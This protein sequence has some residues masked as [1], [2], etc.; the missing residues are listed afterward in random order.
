[1]IEP[2]ELHGKR[3]FGYSLGDLGLMLPRTFEGVFIF[4]F[5]VYTI[6]LNSLLVSI[7]FSAQLI[8]GAISAIIFGVIVDNKKPGK[9]GKRRPFLILGLPIWFI[10]TILVWY[11][12]NCPIDNSF[13]L[14][15]AS[16]FWISIIVRAISHALIYTVYTSMLPE[17]SQT[18]KNREKIASFSSFF[19]IIASVLAL[20]LPIIIQSI[21]PDPKMVKWWNPSGQILSFFIPL[22]GL[23]FGVFGL[24]TTILVFVSVDESFY[25]N[26]Y[27]SPLEK[28]KVK[29]AFKRISIPIK[30]KNYL[31]L[32][33]AAFFIAANSRIVGLLVFPFQTYV[34][35]FQ[36]AQ[37]YIYIIFS[38]LTK[39]IWYYIWKKVLKRFNILTSYSA[40]ILF[41]VFGS[42]IDIFFLF[43]NL[44]FEFSLTLYIIS[45][46][47]VL[48]SMYAFPLFSIPMTASL[49]HDAANKENNSSFDIEMSKIS[50][51]YYGL[52]SFSKTLGPAFASLFI[53]AILSGNNE[54]N[55]ELIT[56]CFLSLGFFYLIAF[57][58]I[59]KIKLSKTSYY[60][61]YKT[62]D[63]Q[64]R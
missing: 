62:R 15:T 6:N 45:W 56:I 12:P 39:F 58:F 55:R 17:Q 54:T 63:G 40:C 22:I 18:F 53:G 34:M 23:S 57:L 5:Y 16:F 21:L 60:A 43:G 61:N 46:S 28:I 3:L 10:S 31:K 50:G 19:Q 4:Q 38:I 24:I 59:N 51:S 1:M 27:N 48:G 30:N 14:P 20:M 37:F 26:N 29:E 41:A 9:Y 52:Y 32:I 7:G 33:I 44:S 36:A 64:R 35:R 42:F 47:I 13:Y 11:P 25:N 8:I 2:R 49:V